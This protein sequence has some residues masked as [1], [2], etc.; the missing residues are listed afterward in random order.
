MGAPGQNAER[1]TSIINSPILLVF[2]IITLVRPRT[3]KND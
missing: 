1:E 2:L 3:A